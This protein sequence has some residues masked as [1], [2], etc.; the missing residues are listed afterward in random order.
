MIKSTKIT[1]LQNKVSCL[2]EKLGFMNCK[3][4]RDENDEMISSMP[5]SEQ[6]VQEK[7]YRIRSS[8]WRMSILLQKNTFAQHFC[9]L[10]EMLDNRSKNFMKLQNVVA[11][12]KG[13]LVQDKEEI[14]S[15]RRQKS[16][17][18][19]RVLQLE[20]EL[21]K[22]NFMNVRIVELEKIVSSLERYVKEHDIDGL[23]RKLQDRECKIG[24]LRNQIVQLKEMSR[25]QECQLGKQQIYVYLY[26]ISSSII[27]K[28]IN[29][30]RRK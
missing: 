15:L 28:K 16:L 1:R 29:N 27:L 30:L 17:H 9:E 26:F 12:L 8:R 20:N 11:E 13:H 5:P 18:T 14:R 4:R 10:Q 2:E 24:Q 25:F 6:D 19:D 21:E 22:Y 7:C 3:A 23:K